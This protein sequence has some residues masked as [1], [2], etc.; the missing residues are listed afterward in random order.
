MDRD[1]GAPVAIGG[2]G[3]SGTRVISALLRAAGFRNGEDLNEALD[4][5][6]FTITHKRRAFTESWPTEAELDQ[7]VR[8]FRDAMTVGLEGLLRAED[9]AVLDRIRADLPPEGTWKCG[10][11]ADSVDRMMASRAKPPGPWGWKEP[12]T[13]IFLPALDARLPG[14]RYIHVV[15]DA[16]DMALSSNTQQLRNWGP[17]PTEDAPVVLRQL[18]FWT[19][20]NARAL[21]YGAGM[22]D[23]FLVI[24]YEDFCARPKPHWDRLVAF[25][26]PEAGGDFPADLVSPPT[27]G[28]GAQLE[29]ETVPE[30]DRAAAEAVTARVAALG[31]V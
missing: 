13:H 17:R 5:R 30:A 27:I 23:R 15:R 7:A 1:Y 25:L 19:D 10:A 29:P 24:S 12:N 18:R 26:G 4:N 3:G 31:R 2:L 28:R 20:A 9:R 16:A 22:G 11:F 6:W 14:L 8:L 21:D